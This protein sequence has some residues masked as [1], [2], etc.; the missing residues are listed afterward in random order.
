MRASV[1]VTIVCLCVTVLWLL[2]VCLEVC[3]GARTFTAIAAEYECLG[4]CLCPLFACV[5]VAFVVGESL[6]L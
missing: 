2:H 1:R 4:V 3:D 5:C 6:P